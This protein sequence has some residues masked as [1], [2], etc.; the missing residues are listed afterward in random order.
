MSGS[1]SWLMVG[2]SLGTVRVLRRLAHDK[3]EVLYRTRVRA[4]DRFVV[5]SRPRQ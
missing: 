4:G 1:R 5:T 2:I 3:P